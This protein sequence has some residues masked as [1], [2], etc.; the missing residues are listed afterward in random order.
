MLKPTP[1]NSLNLAWKVLKG[2]TV[3]LQPWFKIR[4]VSWL[5]IVAYTNGCHKA[6]K[7]DW[8]YRGL[9]QSFWQ[10]EI[11]VWNLMF[12]SLGG[13]FS[14]RHLIP[15]AT[16]HIVL[17]EKTLESP[18]D[19]KEIQPVH[20]K[21]NH[22]WISIGRTD[23]E[24]ETPILWPPDEKSWVICKDPDAGKDWGQERMT[25]D[26]MVGWHHRLNGHGFGQTSSWVRRRLKAEGVSP[27]PPP[28]MNVFEIEWHKVCRPQ[29]GKQLTWI[30]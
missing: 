26:E 4:R 19:C 13:Q 10:W 6:Y 1:P 9:L 24:A 7:G 12:V 23:A 3:R 8:L 15:M 29:P 11:L 17:R 30:G 5:D 21:G 22:S 16:R 28:T 27:G 20:P 14:Q 2:D 25:E 18:L